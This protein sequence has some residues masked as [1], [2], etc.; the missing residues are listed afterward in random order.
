MEFLVKVPATSANLGPGFDALGLALDLWNESVFETD[1]VTDE[2]TN[3]RIAI[4]I[5]IN[6][7]GAGKLPENKNNLILH[8]AHRLAEQTGKSLP[9]FRLR[10]INRIPLGSGLGSSAAAILT[11]LLGANA[12]LGNPLSRDEILN[13]AAEMEGHP[14]NVSAALMGGLVVSTI[15]NEE[16][17][18]HKIDVGPMAIT[19]VTPDLHFP[20][21]QARAA[22]PK[23]VSMKDAVYNISRAVLAAKAFECGDLELLG[24]VMEDKLHQPYRLPLIPGAQTVMN[25]AKRAGAAA[26]ALSGAGPSLIAFSAKQ[27]AGIGKAM[28][29]VFESFGLSARVFELE[30]S[31]EG[32]R[33]ESG[34]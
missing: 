22:L 8:T 5:D 11:G 14:D 15:V 16:I 4:S 23:Q 2:Q 13:L 1:S 24:R 29:L 33:V 34:K 27:D 26:V 21:Q 25:A 17:I 12:L 32:A 7:E 20:T 18:A 31:E 9:S 28:K 3:Q 10:C 30:V 19:V 6:G